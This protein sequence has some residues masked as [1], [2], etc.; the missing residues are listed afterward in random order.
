MGWF[1]VEARSWCGRCGSSGEGASR[2]G[3]DERGVQRLWFGYQARMVQ[4]EDRVR[5]E[6]L[7]RLYQE[8]EGNEEVSYWTGS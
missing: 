1:G 5:E 4:E 6:A 7:A 8:A 2:R 3:A